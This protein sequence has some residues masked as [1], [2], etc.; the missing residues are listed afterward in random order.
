MDKK[1][2]RTVALF[3]FVSYAIYG[4]VLFPLDELFSNDVVL[5]ATLWSDLIYQLRIWSEPLLLSLMFGF[6][7]FGI[8]RYGAANLRPLYLLCGGV[9]V[10]GYLARLISHSVLFGSLDLTLDYLSALVSFLT[11]CGV[12]ALLVL[13]AHVKIAPRIAQNKGK[14]RAAA[15]LGQKFEESAG[16]FPFQKIFSRDN[17]LQKSALFGVSLLAAVRL[18]NFFIAVLFAGIYD[19]SDIPFFLLNI[20]LDILVPFALGYFLTLWII[21][22]L[23][24]RLQ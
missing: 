11:E 8:C 17:E 14:A 15:L 12:V 22:F 4:F 10:F 20:V 6:L 1:I 3:L 16:L 24:R 7:I 9:L 2:L 21:R 18:V 23:F 5:A 19:S 13:F